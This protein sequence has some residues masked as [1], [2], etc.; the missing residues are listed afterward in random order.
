MDRKHSDKLLRILKLQEEGI[1]LCEHQASLASPYDFS[2]MVK[3]RKGTGW[4]TNYATIKGHFLYFWHEEKWDSKMADCMPLIKGVTSIVEKDDKHPH[5]LQIRRGTA[6][7]LL[8]FDSAG[9]ANLWRKVVDSSANSQHTKARLR[10]RIQHAAGE[11]RKE[12]VKAAVAES[13]K[14]NLPEDEF[15]EQSSKCIIL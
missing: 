15:E 1:T 9:E 3:R 2:G 4:A 5:C 8:S 10:K 11:A 6:F 7:C 13:C 14:W 12:W